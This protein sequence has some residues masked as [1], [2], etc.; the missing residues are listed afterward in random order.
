MKW[1]DF[2]CVPG[3][4]DLLKAPALFR[5]NKAFC[6]LEKWASE[7]SWKAFPL[8]SPAHLERKRYNPTLRG[9]QHPHWDEV[10]QQLEKDGQS[11]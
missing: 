4:S 11:P 9:I 6:V 8:L 2:S 3:E 1:S 7:T 10:Q 5:A